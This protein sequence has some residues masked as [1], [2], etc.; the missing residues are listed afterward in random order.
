MRYVHHHDQLQYDLQQESKKCEGKLIF[1]NVYV[2]SSL[3]SQLMEMEMEMKMEMD[4][5]GDGDEDGD[6]DGWR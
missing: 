6:G 3:K 1:E 4:G 2:R 5:D